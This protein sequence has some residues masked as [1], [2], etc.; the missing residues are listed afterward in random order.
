MPTASRERCT[1]TKTPV[2]TN[3]WFDLIDLQINI[4]SSMKSV[5][6]VGPHIR[7]VYHSV[8]SVRREKPD[9]LVRISSSHRH[10][11]SCCSLVLVIS[12][13]CFSLLLICFP[14]IRSLVLICPGLKHSF[15]LLPPLCSYAWH[16][17]G[18]K[19][20]RPSLDSPTAARATGTS[21]LDSRTRGRVMEPHAFTHTHTL[22]NVE[23]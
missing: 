2:N 19:L 5:I 4:H 6:L 17:P 7:K 10:G 1:Q 8:P 16:S 18:A 15:F 20:V 22:T 14:L 12:V 11:F 9:F 23:T 3:S 21:L 13:D